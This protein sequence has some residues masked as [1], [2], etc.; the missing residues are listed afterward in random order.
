[1][2]FKSTWWSVE[3]PNG[4]SAHRE[5]NC[6]IFRA[7][8][9]LGVLQISSA[10]KGAGVVTDRDLTE[11]AEERISPEIRLEGVIFG[12]FSGTTAKY[13]KDGLFWQEW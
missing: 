3:L 5:E 4:W 10:R 12:A 2:V 13:R 8:L 6:A 7:E 1:M 11:F 9:P